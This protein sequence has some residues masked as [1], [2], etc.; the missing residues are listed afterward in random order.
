MVNVL[1]HMV[2]HSSYFTVN[3]LV[4]IFPKILGTSHPLQQSTN[5]GLAATARLEM[6]AFSNEAS[7]VGYRIKQELGYHGGV[8]R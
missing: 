7:V 4:N 2:N 5:R 3:G 6:Y 1:V 8:A